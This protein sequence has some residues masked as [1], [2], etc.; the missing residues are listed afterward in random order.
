[1]VY[2][3]RPGGDGAEAR[4]QSIVGYVDMRG[5]FSMS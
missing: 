1:M 3:S 2:T 4:N 5:V